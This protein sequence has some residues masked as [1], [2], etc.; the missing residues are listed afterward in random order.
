MEFFE[1]QYSSKASVT[2][3]DENRPKT[4]NGPQ[5]VETSEVSSD[6]V[7]VL[8]PEIK[9]EIVSSDDEQMMGEEE[10]VSTSFQPSNE[11]EANAT[12]S[13]H[14]RRNVK[15]PSLDSNL[16]SPSTSYPTFMSPIMDYIKT[17]PSIDI[18]ETE[19]IVLEEVKTT[20]GSTTTVIKREP[21]AESAEVNP[22]KRSKLDTAPVQPKESTSNGKILLLLF[23]SEH[24]ELIVVRNIIFSINGTI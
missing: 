19:G 14:N 2:S 22:A 9:H 23:F 12:G 10:G 3:V 11:I 1:I 20:S 8:K 21:S 18:V 15:R 13:T 16:C 6:G 4:E 24:F 5:K 7:T 17:G